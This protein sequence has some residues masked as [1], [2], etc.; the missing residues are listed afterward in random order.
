MGYKR[1]QLDNDVFVDKFFKRN[2]IKQ[3]SRIYLYLFMKDINNGLQKI[4]VG[5]DAPETQMCNRDTTRH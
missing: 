5:K 1:P 3:I 4:P 2:E